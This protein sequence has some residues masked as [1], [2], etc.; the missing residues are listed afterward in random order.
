MQKNKGDFAFSFFFFLNV[1]LMPCSVAVHLNSRSDPKTAT[2][3]SLHLGLF[4]GGG[5]GLVCHFL[6]R[7]ALQREQSGGE[8]Q[9]AP[10]FRAALIAA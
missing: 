10:G 8:T 2:L 9:G 4:L 1:I 5:A 6:H 7:D 3:A